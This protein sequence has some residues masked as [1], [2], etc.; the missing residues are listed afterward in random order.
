MGYRLASFFKENVE[1]AFST[2]FVQKKCSKYN[3]QLPD[4]SERIKSEEVMVISPQTLLNRY[5]ISNIDLLQ[6]DV[7]GYDFEVIKI[8][9]IQITQPKAIIFE[10]IHLSEQDMELCVA[11]LKNCNYAV[12]RFDANTLAMLYP[13]GDFSKYFE[14]KKSASNKQ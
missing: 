11:H 2:G 13:L 5:N 9:D 10:H 3:I 7:E 12:R 1:K 14:N 8:F 4:P 6:I